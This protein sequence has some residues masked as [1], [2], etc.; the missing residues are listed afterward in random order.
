[1]SSCR[2]VGPWII[3]WQNRRRGKN[4]PSFFPLAP[5]FFNVHPSRSSTDNGI[6]TL[7]FLKKH[8]YRL[9]E[10]EQRE[11]GDY[12]CFV[13]NS[14]RTA[15]SRYR[16]DKH[17]A[18]EGDN[19]GD[20]R[21]IV[22]RFEDSERLIKKKKKNHIT[23]SRHHSFF[24]FFYTYFWYI[25]H[26]FRASNWISTRSIL[27]PRISEEGR[28]NISL[29]TWGDLPSRNGR[30]PGNGKTRHQDTMLVGRRWEWS[31]PPSRWKT[32]WWISRCSTYPW[33]PSWHPL[34]LTETSQHREHERR[35]VVA[36]PWNRV[37]LSRKEAWMPSRVGFNFSSPL[38][39]LR[40]LLEGLEGN[41]SRFGFGERD[42]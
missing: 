1:M 2:H 35:H 14:D 20:K 11:G 3:R 26:P 22:R 28:K 4:S 34:S 29:F 17:W 32:T 42:F 36:M 9:L 7:H 18:T 33:H 27:S 24:T 39:S 41:W 8:R 19:E 15:P 37:R 16:R 25:D 21:E 6:F 38:L 40:S 31:R 12:G 30:R 10:E 23:F 13:V 5:S